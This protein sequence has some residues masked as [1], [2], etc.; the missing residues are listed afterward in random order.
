MF[1]KAQIL[2]PIDE[3]E[4]DTHW[5][6]GAT[7]RKAPEEGDDQDG[8]ATSP[9]RFKVGVS[10]MPMWGIS[11]DDGGVD[12]DQEEDLTFLT[13]GCVPRQEVWS[14]AAI[15]TKAGIDDFCASA[16]LNV[17]CPDDDGTAYH[18]PTIIQSR[19]FRPCSR[20]SPAG[21]Y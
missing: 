6:I 11:A 20:G 3:L 4:G 10:A 15:T 21:G 13:F 2:S 16:A 7:K 1:S 9:K 19:V 14:S 18:Q 5:M 12:D 17:Y 8:N